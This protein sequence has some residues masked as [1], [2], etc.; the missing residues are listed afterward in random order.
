MPTIFGK[1][2]E[3][4]DIKNLCEKGSKTVDDL[5]IIFG[6]IDWLSN[7]PEAS[8]I[9]L[10]L[11]PEIQKNIDKFKSN[12]KA[13]LRIGESLIVSIDEFLEGSPCKRMKRTSKKKEGII[14]MRELFENVSNKDSFKN[15]CNL[16]D[17][18]EKFLSTLITVIKKIL[19]Y[20]IITGS[21]IKKA[22]G[23]PEKIF[24][25]LEK[26]LISLEKSFTFTKQAN[27]IICTNLKN[28]AN[29]KKQ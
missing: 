7:S 3:A 8:T 25:S 14:M 18:T 26:M 21:V 22:G 16:I 20:K 9:I 29:S 6:G 13:P 5:D 12:S 28:I 2:I 27:K 4:S 1:K 19:D 11:D 23:N 10:S 15:M 17:T 24:S